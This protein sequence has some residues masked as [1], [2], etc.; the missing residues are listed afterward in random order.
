MYMYIYIYIHIYIYIFTY[1]HNTTYTEHIYAKN[2]HNIHTAQYTHKDLGI[3]IENVGV[4]G[5]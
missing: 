4:I 3:R 2:V 5:V 1:I